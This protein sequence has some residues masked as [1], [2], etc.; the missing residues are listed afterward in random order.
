MKDELL[1]L[2]KTRRS[3]RQYRP[4][5][6]ADGALDAVLEAGTWAASGNGR[7]SPVLVAVQDP[8]DRAALARMNAAVMGRDGDPYYGAPTV[9]LVLADPEIGT[10]VEDGSLALGNM[11]LQA[12]ALGLGSCWIHRERQ[13]FA[14][15][16]GKALLRKWGLDEKLEGVGSIAL[17][18]PEGELPQPKPR[19]EG[20]AVKIR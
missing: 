4:D 1:D 6:I 10:W 5:Q 16:E 15:G 12:H 11:M 9:V 19:K 7:Q 18:Y 20:Y 17:G 8:E 3:V 13:M 14:S 2:I